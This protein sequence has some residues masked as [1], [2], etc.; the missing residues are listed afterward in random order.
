MGTKVNDRD[1]EELIQPFSIE[2]IREAVFQILATKSPGPDGF[3][4]GFFQD[5]W[6]VVD[7]DIIRMVQ[8]VHHSGRLLQEM[9]YTYCINP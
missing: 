7:G 9:S 8:T 2:E 5:L 3:T 6:E 1:N 4:T